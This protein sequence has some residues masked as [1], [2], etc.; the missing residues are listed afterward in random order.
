MRVLL[1]GALAAVLTM[2]GLTAC[3]DDDVPTAADLS[4]DLVS[5]DDLDGEW[6]V[7]TGPPGETGLPSGIVAAGQRDL[8][9]SLDLCPEAPMAAQDAADNLMWDDFRQLEMTVDDPVDPPADMEGHKVFAQQ[10]L[11]GGEAEALSATFGALREGLLACLG[12]IPAGEEGAG[13]AEEIVLPLLGDEQIAVF[14][15]FAEAGGDGTWN[16]YEIIVRKGDVLMAMVV[17][18]VWLGDLEPMIGVEE[19]QDMVTMAADKI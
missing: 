6:T 16:L 12:D 15:E 14:T 10:F 8:L 17:G 13:S 11:M 5:E 18:D 2:T 4:G 19:F 1:G 7:T 9:P 3:G